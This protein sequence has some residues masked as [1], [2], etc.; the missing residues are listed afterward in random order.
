VREGEDALLA[1]L[2]GDEV[3]QRRVALIF[4][5]QVLD[6]LRELVGG[7][8]ALETGIG[9]D[10]IAGIHDPVRVADDDGVG[11]QRLGPARNLHMP[12]DGLFPGAG[13][14]ARLLRHQH[15][16][17]MRD[18]RCKNDFAHRASSSISDCRRK[19]SN[20]HVNYLI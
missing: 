10:V 6:E 2:F 14:P 4:I 18:F 8:D 15:R 16:R 19:Y 3:A 7:E 12:V 20:S 11:P 13:D 1:R 5:F 9:I 17:N